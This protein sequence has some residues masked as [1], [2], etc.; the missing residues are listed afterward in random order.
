MLPPVTPA[1]YRRIPRLRNRSE[2]R[3]HEVRQIGDSAK[4]LVDLQAAYVPAIVHATVTYFT[5]QNGIVYID[6]YRIA[7]LHGPLELQTCTAFGDLTNVGGDGLA[8]VALFLQDSQCRPLTDW[9]TR[10]S[11][12]LHA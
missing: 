8:G 4:D 2:Y 10:L 12:T 6:P 9:K 7:G 1:W 5:E 11:S 3:I